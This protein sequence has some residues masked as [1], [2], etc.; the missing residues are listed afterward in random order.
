[1]AQCA[2][3]LW[4]ETCSPIPIDVPMQVTELPP[5][6]MYVGKTH[7]SVNDIRS[8][9]NIQR[10]VYEL[11]ENDCRWVLSTY[12]HKVLLLAG[13]PCIG[14]HYWGILQRSV[15]ACSITASAVAG[16]M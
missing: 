7:V 16:T 15:M 3:T 8:F 4:Q 5:K 9:N 11:N 6:H 12:S 14:A 13:Y 1:M 10:L 2:A